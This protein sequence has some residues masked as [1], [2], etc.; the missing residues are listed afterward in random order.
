MRAPGHSRCCFSVITE[1]QEQSTNVWTGKEKETYLQRAFVHVQ[2][3]VCQGLVS[4]LLSHHSSAKLLPF[5]FKPCIFRSAF[6]RSEKQHLLKINKN[7]ITKKIIN[8]KGKLLIHLCV[9]QLTSFT[10]V[11]SNLSK[12]LN[13][14]TSPWAYTACL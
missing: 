6:S 3:K 1:V 14:L 8:L 11:S 7:S 2:I 9:L 13:R 5:Q 12:F 4:K 10:E